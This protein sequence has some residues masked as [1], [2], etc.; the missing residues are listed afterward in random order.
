M[1]SLGEAPNG[2]LRFPYLF[3]L[4]YLYLQGFWRPLPPKRGTAPHLSERSSFPRN[5]PR[6][7]SLILNDKHVT[8]RKN[9]ANNS[10]ALR[11]RVTPIEARSPDPVLL[12]ALR[13]PVQQLGSQRGL[14][15]M[16]VA[17]TKSNPPN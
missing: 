7:R 16:G 11:A 2:Y 9:A 10:P 14:A 1:P 15:R 12:Q 3:R 5:V 17:N 4:I 8:G 6:L 13:P